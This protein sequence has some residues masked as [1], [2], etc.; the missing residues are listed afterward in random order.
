MSS[1]KASLKARVNSV[2]NY[3]KSLSKRRKTPVVC[4]EKEINEFPK[5]SNII[6]SISSEEETIVEEVTEPPIK[7]KNSYMHFVIEKRKMLSSE[8]SNM[9]FS[10]QGKYLGHLWRELDYD[11]KQTYKD[12]A[13]E[14]KKRYERQLKLYNEHTN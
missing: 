2:I 4:E 8:L 7:N 12:I 6:E 5:K 3:F 14:D 1:L 13:S 10:E 9:K 11:S